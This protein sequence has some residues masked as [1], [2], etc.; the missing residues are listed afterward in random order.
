MTVFVKPQKRLHSEAD[1]A[2]FVSS[3]THDAILNFMTRLAKSVHGLQLTDKSLPVNESIQGLLDL[4]DDIDRISDSHPIEKHSTSRFGKVEFRDFCDD[5]SHQA[6]QLIKNHIHLQDNCIVELRTYLINSFGDKIRIDYGS[7]HE[8]NFLCFLY[9]LDYL[10]YFESKEYDKSVVL[11]VFARYI[12]TM[13][14]LQMKYWL[15]PAGSHGVWGLDDYHFLPFLFGAAQL[16]P[17]KRPRPLSIHN[18]DYVAEFKEKYLYFACI[19]FINKTKTGVTS[20][21]QSSPMLDDIS[22]VK[23]WKK[24]E[25]GMVKMYDAEVLSKLPVVQHFFFGSILPCPDGVAA[26]EENNADGIEEDSCCHEVHSTWGDC[27]GIKVPSA[28]AASAMEQKE[29]RISF[30]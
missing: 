15:E 14:K 13:R 4:L 25:E 26:S 23:T 7:G 6:D 1:L 12:T 28:V 30:C 8:L 10:G 22:G 19:D 3:P 27:C 2:K 24:I 9:C 18:L 11:K 5:F 21:R 20:L 17:L 29:H 16:S